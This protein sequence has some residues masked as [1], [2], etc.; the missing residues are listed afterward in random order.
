M[1]DV[2]IDNS[3]ELDFEEFKVLVKKLHGGEYGFINVDQ[4]K[5]HDNFFL[6]SRNSTIE[7]VDETVAVEK[8]F[9]VKFK[10]SKTQVDKTQ[11]VQQV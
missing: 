2:D 6:A 3:N 10:S 4:S 11:K 1:K 9:G 5:M 7:K 8:G